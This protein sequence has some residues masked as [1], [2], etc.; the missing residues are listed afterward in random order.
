MPFL[1]PKYFCCSTP[2]LSEAANTSS[3]Q[4]QMFTAF[5]H[6]C[7]F[8]GNRAREVEKCFFGPNSINQE[9]GRLGF[10]VTLCQVWVLNS[11]WQGTYAFLNLFCVCFC[12]AGPSKAW[13]LE[14]NPLTPGCE[15][16]YHVQAF[17]QVI[18]F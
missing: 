14:Q 3:R 17:R 9:S 12:Y 1:L 11:G 16:S 15:G 6:N 8:R 2:T 18:C 5:G 13:N 10:K 7:I 4:P